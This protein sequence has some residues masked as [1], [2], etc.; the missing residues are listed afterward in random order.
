M[1]SLSYDVGKICVGCLA[2]CLVFVCP[3]Q[4]MALE[5]YTGDLSRRVTLRLNFRVK[6][7]L[8]REYLWTVRYGNGYT[9]TLLLEVFTQKHCSRLHSTEI[10]F[11]LKQNSLFEQPFE[12]L[13]GNVRT[14]S[15]AR[16]KA[17]GQLPIRH[18][19]TF[20]TISYGWDVIS[21]NLSKS[22]FLEGRWIT[23]SANFRRKGTS[24]ATTVGV[25]QWRIQGGGRGTMPPPPLA[26]WKIVLP[27]Y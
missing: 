24:P 4:C 7:Y 25:R 8:S 22:A 13:R 20:P 11:Y 6:D 18:D 16:W 9:T 21:G 26:A 15:M 19:W 23:L 5:R 2:F 12:D 3:M 14:P 17:H 1:W 27:V 10:E